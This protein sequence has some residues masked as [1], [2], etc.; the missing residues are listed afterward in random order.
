ML[1]VR[2]YCSRN[3][4]IYKAFMVLGD[5]AGH[6]HT[7]ENLYPEIYIVFMPPNTSCN[8]QPMDQAFKA[9]SK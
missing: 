6:P 2:Q 5:P 9:A 8:V 7:L 4:F 1:A 3:N